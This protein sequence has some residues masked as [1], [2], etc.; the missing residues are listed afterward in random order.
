M[1]FQLWPLSMLLSQRSMVPVWLLNV[2]VPVLAVAHTVSLP[3]ML[4]GMV[5]VEMVISTVSL[6][7][8]HMPLLIVHI[9]L[10]T[11]GC[12]LV[13]DVLCVAML[14]MIVAVG[15][16]SWLHLPDPLVGML[17]FNCKVSCKQIVLFNPAAAR[18]TAWYTVITAVSLYSDKHTPLCTKALYHVVLLKLL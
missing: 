11:P 9:K 8:A 5:G 15:P 3:A 17:A 4:P 1:L 7:S 13:T 6:L 14:L 16:E 18:V 12:R 10:Y 2:N